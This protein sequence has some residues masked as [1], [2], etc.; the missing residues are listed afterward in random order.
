MDILSSLSWE[1]AERRFR[2]SYE[3]WKDA[4]R[5]T[6]KS[7]PASRLPKRSET[8]SQLAVWL[9]GDRANSLFKK[10]SLSTGSM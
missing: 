3:D 4:K 10:G 9:E 6:L 5:G 2:V 1:E 7:G 8:F